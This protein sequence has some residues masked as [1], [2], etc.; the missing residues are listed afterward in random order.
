MVCVPVFG[1]KSSEKKNIIAIWNEQTNHYTKR[2]SNIVK[3]EL[4][5]HKGSS[6]FVQVK[7]NSDTI[8]GFVECCEF[9]NNNKVSI[10]K[11]NLLFSLGAASSVNMDTSR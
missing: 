1:P 9:R 6:L 2:N 7:Y 8:F 5:V 11:H 3:K 4:L 10:S